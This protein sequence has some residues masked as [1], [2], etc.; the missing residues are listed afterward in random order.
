MAFASGIPGLEVTVEVDSTALPEH[1]YVGVE[2][3]EVTTSITKYIEAPPAT[4]FSVRYLYRPPFTPPLAIQ[5]DIVL[6]GNYVQA[7]FIEWGSKE[8][9]EGYLCSRSTS[10]NGGHSFTQGFQFAELRTNETNTPITKEIADRLSPVGRIVLY[11]YFI[12]HLEAVKPADVP[13]LANNEF[14]SLSEKALHK[15]AAAQGDELSHHTSLDIPVQ[16]DTVTYNEVK[17]TGNEPFATFTFLY[18]SI[19]AL[20]SIGVIPR[21]PS[22]SVDPESEDE[23][24]D[25]EDMTEEEMRTEL[26]RMRE[27]RQEATRI[28]RER[29]EESQVRDAT[30]VGDD[31]VQW[32]RSQPTERHRSIFIVRLL[33]CPIFVPGAMAIV[34]EVPG[35]EVQIHIN[36]NP[37]R[38]YIDRHTAV[39]EAISESYVE[40]HSDSTFEI[41]YSFR[42]PFPIDRPVCMIV[43]MDGKDVDEPL[44]RPDE[45]YEPEGHVSSGPISN[46][47]GNWLTKP[48]RFS[49]LDIREYNEVPIAEDLQNKIRPIGIITCEFYFLNDVK[50]NP[51]TSFA[52]KELEKLHT[53]N[54]KAIKGESLSHQAIL[55]DTEPTEEIEYYDAEYADGGEPFATFHFYYRSLAALKDL[56]IVERTPDPVE[57]LDSDDTVLGQL[58]REQLEAIVRRFR[59]QEETRVRMKRELSD[60]STVAGEDHEFGSR[61]GI[62][63]DDFIELRSV[64]LRKKRKQQR[65]R[66]IPTDETKV[67][68]LD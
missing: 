32:V 14:D 19:D 45:L 2:E 34:N 7:P 54:E 30:L 38:E 8:D 13:R 37:L 10:S 25:P 50:R 1:E 21:T 26:K 62:C 6:D 36:G 22:P 33:C 24:K 3:D 67:I 4:D 35:L 68:E 5:M 56:H 59:E 44:I 9:C 40:A 17:T 46:N 27:K 57:V 11:F 51:K 28:K 53:V 39:S 64:D 43:T 20:K 63:D 15:A 23:D 41:H 48:Y 60:T 42:A 18:R 52:H 58:N 12:E 55:G 61:S 16:R 66:Q 65:V 47:G 49:P 29:E 31:E